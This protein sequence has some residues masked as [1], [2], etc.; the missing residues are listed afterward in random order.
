MT[1]F[2][3]WARTIL[4]PSIL[5]KVDFPDIFVPV[6]TIPLPLILIELGTGFFKTGC[7][8]STT[9]NLFSLMNLGF[10]SLLLLQAL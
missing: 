9:F 4:A 5:K 1:K 3:V 2:I 7:T 6:R 8:P 10:D